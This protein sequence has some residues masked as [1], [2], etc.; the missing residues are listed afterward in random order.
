MSRW[1]MALLVTAG[2][3]GGG[4]LGFYVQRREYDKYLV[5]LAMQSGAGGGGGYGWI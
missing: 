5:S 4:L 1:A 3:L 2:A